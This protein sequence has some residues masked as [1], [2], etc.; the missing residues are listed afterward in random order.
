MLTT[1]SPAC[2]NCLEVLAAS[3][4]WK[5]KCISR[6]EISQP[7]ILHWKKL[8]VQTEFSLPTYRLNYQV[9]EYFLSNLTFLKLKI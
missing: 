4:S 9:D 2:A 3:A 1:L 7:F 8:S 6:P 5:A